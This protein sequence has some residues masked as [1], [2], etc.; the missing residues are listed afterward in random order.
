MGISKRSAADIA[1]IRAAR[2]KVA[3][4][5]AHDLV[6][7]PIFAR[8]DA[9]LAASKHEDP[10]DLARALIRNLKVGV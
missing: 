10:A 8:L 1:R 5:V 2:D 7:A 3:I 6:Y 4:L 9:E